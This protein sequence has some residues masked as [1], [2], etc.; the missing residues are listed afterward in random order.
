MQSFKAEPANDKA[1]R[2][3]LH[4][5]LAGCLQSDYWRKVGLARLADKRI[6]PLVAAGAD[7]E[8]MIAGF[9]LVIGDY[10]YDY[11]L[12]TYALTGNRDMRDLLMADYYVVE[13]ENG[14][15]SQTY[16]K[17]IKPDPT[18][19]A[20]GQPL[21]RELR[22]G[23]I[24]SQW[25][26]A[27][28]TMFSALPRTTAAQAYR[29]YLDADIAN[30]EGLR[31]VAGQPVDVDHRG[32]AA[33]RCANCHST[34]DPLAYAFAKYEGIQYSADL[35]FGDYRPERLSEM[36]PDWNDALE[37]PMLFGQPVNSLVEWA[38]VA[39][40]SPAFQR[41][42]VD[43][44]FRQA[45]GHPPGPDDQTEFVAMVDAVPKDGYSAEQVISRLVDS[46]AFGR[47]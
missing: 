47:P 37:Q 46:N 10:Q 31:P 28:N 44:F 34:L 17:V 7:S 42:M 38:Q 2:G 1:L 15:L 6:R 9:R 3:R 29:A 41:N 22:A 8:I 39:A 23:M 12:W 14:E 20:G 19:L 32:V 33:E 18:A 26:L 11:R 25:F 45:L 35:R 27:I 24:S 40:N 21:S 13:D 43:L 4:D 30:S 5:A 16:D 36:M